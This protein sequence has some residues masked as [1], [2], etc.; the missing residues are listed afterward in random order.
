ML[1]CI[2]LFNVQMKSIL[3]VAELEHKRVV[4]SLESELRKEKVHMYMYS[5]CVYLTLVKLFQ[6]H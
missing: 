2:S 3:S 4:N 5:V 1:K 6:F